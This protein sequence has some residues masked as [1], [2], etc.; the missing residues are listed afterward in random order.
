MRIGDLPVSK[1]TINWALDI[2]CCDQFIS[3]LEYGINTSVGERGQLLSGGQRQRIAIARAILHKPSI[4]LLDELH[5]HLMCLL[6]LIY[7]IT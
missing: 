7:L 2:A 4:L 1:E 6:N 3:L 5:L